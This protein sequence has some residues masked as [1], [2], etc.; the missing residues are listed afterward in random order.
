MKL[1]TVVF[2]FILLMPRVFADT[3][4]F[5]GGCFWCME[6]PFDGVNGVN[7]TE[8]GYI[9]GPQKNPT[10]QQVS[11]GQTQHLEAVRVTFDPQKVSYDQLLTVFWRNIDPTDGGGQF[12]DRG[13][14]YTTAIFYLGEK[15]KAVAL[16]SLKKLQKS[17]IFKNPIQ[18]VLREATTFYL[19]E[20]YH[21][22]YYRKNP[23]TYKFYRLNSG[24]DEYLKKIWANQSI[25]EG[26]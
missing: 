20:G 22:D 17:N 26:L 13:Y 10:Y 11:S 8:V 23:R 1:A 9:G 14:Q 24:R 6:P 7:K 16:N 12:V 15:Q 5:A 2:S 25:K 3:A 18:T 19:A 21:Q 4:I